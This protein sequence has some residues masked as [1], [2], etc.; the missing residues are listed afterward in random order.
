MFRLINYLR[1][2]LIITSSVDHAVPKCSK[3]NA[4]GT[5][6]LFCDDKSLIVDG[7]LS[8]GCWS[9]RECDQCP[10][11]DI[12]VVLDWCAAVMWAAI[13]MSHLPIDGASESVCLLEFVNEGGCCART[14]IGFR[15]W[16]LVVPLD[17]RVL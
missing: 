13:K 14:V 10:V 3:G 4:T 15:K 12:D 7:C 8:S 5:E 11:E 2:S 17:E 1:L 16:M 6:H 9:G